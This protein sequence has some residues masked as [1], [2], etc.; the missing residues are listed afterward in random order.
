MHFLHTESRAGLELVDQLG[1]RKKHIT[2]EVVEKE[3][4]QVR[5]SISLTTSLTSS[6]KSNMSCRPRKLRTGSG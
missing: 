3:Y 1:N 6:L 2:A 5:L 4:C